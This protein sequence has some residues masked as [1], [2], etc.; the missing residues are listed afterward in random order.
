MNENRDKWAE[1]VILVDADYVDKVAFDLIVNFERMIGRRIPQADMARWLECVA[2][3]G[4]LRE[5]E[6]QTQV[7][8]LHKQ[9]KMENFKPGTPDELDGKAFKGFL[10][11]I[12]I[13]C[14]KVE[15]LTTM[16]DL[17]VDSMQII[18]NAKEVK[19]LIVVPNAEHIYNKVR[20]GLRHADDEKRITVLAMQP[21]EGGNF[22]QEILG[23]SLMAALG[24]K[25]E[26]LNKMS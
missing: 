1:N 25:S 20:E 19:R 12:L 9:P 5:G 21:M 10:G 16:D 17:F 13:S 22:R 2:L 15:D 3:D 7:V 24:I 18:A 4:G 23:Y 11:E 6:H 8:L 14:V 26:E